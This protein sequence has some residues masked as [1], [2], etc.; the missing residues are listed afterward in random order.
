ML[1]FNRPLVNFML[2]EGKMLKKLAKTTLTASLLSAVAG[3]SGLAPSPSAQAGPEA[4]KGCGYEG[5]NPLFYRTGDATGT[6]HINSDNDA[7]WTTVQD[8]NIQFPVSLNVNA[9]SGNELKD[10]WVFQGNVLGPQNKI[11]DAQDIEGSSHYEWNAALT[12]GTINLSDD[13]KAQLV[14]TCNATLN[15]SVA[16]QQ[17]YQFSTQIPLSRMYV[18]TFSSGGVAGGETQ[19]ES[20]PLT[21][22]WP[23]NVVCDPFTKKTPALPAPEAAKLPDPE[24]TQVELGLTT[25]GAVVGGTLEYTGSCPMGITL[26]MRWVTNIGTELKTY[27]KHKDLAG[28]HNWTSPVFN[29]TTNQP[30]FGGNYKKEMKDLFSIPFTGS[31]ASNGGGGVAGGNNPGALGFNPSGGGGSNPASGYGAANT[32]TNNGLT[33]YIG[34][35]RLVAYKNKKVVPVLLPG[36]GMSNTTIYEGQKMSGWRKYI[37]NCKPQQNAGIPQIPGGVVNPDN[38]PVNPDDPLNI[39]VVQYDGELDLA[40]SAD[41]PNCSRQGQAVFKINTSSSSPVDYKLTCTGSRSWQGTV[42]MFAN[43]VNTYQGVT[44][45]TFDIIKTENVACVLSRVSNGNN[46]LLAIR[47]KQYNCIKGNVVTDANDLQV[48]PKPG[49]STQVVPGAVTPGKGD[50]IAAD[51]L[52]KRANE[53]KKEAKDARRRKAAA[54]AVAKRRA[55]AVAIAKRKAVAAT[56]AKRRAA[57][58]AMAKRRSVAA[59]L[60][61]KRASSATRRRVAPKRRAIAPVRIMRLRTR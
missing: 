7:N 41:A 17:Q 52:R 50:R 12:G 3:L 54:A 15:P 25:T 14:A 30:A 31:V 34:Y 42:Q 23:V 9:P 32:G 40:D 53:T 49:S 45:I 8:T 21:V 56:L 60:A 19:S 28:Q 27:I 35:F 6:I 51:I 26:N 10:V 58:V 36:G 61:R 24:I 59:A 4:Q 43:G 33:Q 55:A 16:N 2:W 1:I 39:P 44:A 29:V 37:V 57:A 13:E 48:E 20:S 47:A 5:C 22:Y 46:H 11:H 38:G 18:Y